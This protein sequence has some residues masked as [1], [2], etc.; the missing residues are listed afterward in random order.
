[1]TVL[2]SLAVVLSAVLWPGFVAVTP[3][4]AEWRRVDSPNF[5]V[6]GDVGARTL[7]D[8]AVQFEGFR[9]TLTRV[10]S[11]R[12]TS[13]AVPTV[14]IVFPSD[15][16]FTPFKPKYEGRPAAISGLFVSRPDV[17]YIAMVAGG[18][19]E[20]LRI[21]FHEYAHLVVANVAR[22][23]PA[24]V[25]EGL[26]EYYST[27]E[28]ADGGRQAVL[29][30]ALV[31]HIQLLNNT[32]LLKVQTLIGV[33]HDSPLYNERDRKSVFYA[34]AWALTHMMLLGEKPLSQELIAYLQRVDEG[35]SSTEAWQQAFG[36]G[37]FDRALYEYTRRRTYRAI[38]YKFPEKLARFDA[39][40]TALSPADGE[41]FL[42]E[43]LV[44]CDRYDEAAARL[45]AA[46]KLDP[47]NM[48]AKAVRAALA[49]ARNDLAAAGKSLSAVE[50]PPD[51]LVAYSAGTS[52]SEIVQRGTQQPTAEELQTARRLFE[53]VRAQRGEIANALARL[54]DL[55]LRSAEGPSRSTRA[56][57]E[58]ARLMAVG[59]DDYIFLHAQ[60]LAHLEDFGGARTVLGPL[61]RPNQPP[62]VRQHARSLMQ[63]I[64]RLEAAAARESARQAQRDLAPP[65]P[66]VVED[67]HRPP[68]PA[69][70]LFRDLKP[71]E[72]RV[73]GTLERIEC[74]PGGR[75]AFHVR[76]ADGPFR[77][78]APN[79]PD[80]E[81]ITY[82][83][84]LTGTVKC[85]ALQP[86]MGVYLTWRGSDDTKEPR[87][88][89]AVE[90]L[91][92]T[93]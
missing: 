89:V 91:P 62:D 25:N 41:A 60:V 76:T 2:R 26:A 86:G 9:E 93:P 29:G 48:R 68:A 81:F 79:M 40:P 42:A 8:V 13:T 83:D 84:D 17:N 64:V 21:V 71:G 87:V 92:K 1:M 35:T 72:T 70:P 44:H 57:V 67:G 38:Q 49:I 74:M 23:V 20:A 80:V 90:F 36:A 50:A 15:R 51:W 11:E 4:A 54:A 52:M 78:L 66:D 59:R 47:A 75:A 28:V 27:Y 22:N 56:A 58:R 10:L 69:R 65:A 55:E 14:V 3:A 16:A 37:D 82:R 85:G 33:D 73:E 53:I 63:H 12:A 32:P 43:F 5:V 7:R 77:A 45:D 18:G 34:Q 24:W 61:M 19:P 88:A 39:T 6:V 30:R 46:E 31:H